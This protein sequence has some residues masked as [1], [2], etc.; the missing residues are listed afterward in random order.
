[1]RREL[2]DVKL[3]AEGLKT[4]CEVSKVQVNEYLNSLEE[5]GNEKIED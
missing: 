1:M 4:R 5:E 3:V 2:E